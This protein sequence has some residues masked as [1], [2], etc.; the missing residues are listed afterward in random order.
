MPTNPATASAGLSD[1]PPIP[2]SQPKEYV[3]SEAEYRPLAA[4]AQA[5]F[6]IAALMPGMTWA[7]LK[8]AIYLSQH[9]DPIHQ[10]AV[11]GVRDIAGATRLDLKTVTAT[12]TSL[13]GS[14]LITPRQFKGP[15]KTAY[16]LNFL[17]LVA[18]PTVGTIP[19]VTTA[20]VGTT[21]TPEPS[22]TPLLWESFPHPVETQG[23]LDIEEPSITIID[24]LLAAD[25]RKFNPA[26]LAEACRWIHGYQCQF[27]KRHRD[28]P[29]PPKPDN[30]I[31]AR[32]LAL[33]PLETLTRLL[34]KMAQ[35]RIKPGYN[36]AWF[37]AV[38]LQR[39]HGIAPTE[40]ATTR[41]AR[42]TESR[43]AAALRAANKR[44]A[45]PVPDPEQPALPFTAPGLSTIEAVDALERELAQ[46]P[47]A[48]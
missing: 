16:Q 42:K 7:A 22:K 25:P 3:L 29:D 20:R 23:P 46:K 39:I 2:E 36:Y 6:S 19:T 9:A 14:N 15:R 48:L 18:F 33:A 37:E 24:R 12:I 21:P 41:E 8:V 4:A 17:R 35:D 43:E 32:I 34:T 11:A 26:E 45:A 27:G 31:L 38:I 40:L 1:A 10:T 44:T 30:K 13:A 28:Q 47:Q 5:F